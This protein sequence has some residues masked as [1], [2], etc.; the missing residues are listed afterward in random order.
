MDWVPKDIVNK[1]GEIIDTVHDGPFV[2][3]NTKKEKEL[4]DAFSQ[5]KFKCRRDDDL[6][7]LACF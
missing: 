5:H 6:I 2:Y 1:Y 4:I 3:F 7:N